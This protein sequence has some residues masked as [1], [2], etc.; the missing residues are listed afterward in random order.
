MHTNTHSHKLIKCKTDLLLDHAVLGVGVLA[1]EPVE[2]RPVEHLNSYS[3]LVFV[4]SDEP[5]SNTN[6]FEV[7]IR[8]PFMISS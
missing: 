7:N 3:S 6:V 4:V 5:G 8:I 2:P 1:V